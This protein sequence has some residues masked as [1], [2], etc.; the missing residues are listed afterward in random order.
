M[1]QN[2]FS[3]SLPAGRVAGIP[4]RLHW[5]LL[6]YWV[7]ELNSRL[8][9]EGD[10]KLIL[11]FWLLKVGLVFGSILLHELGHA[12]AARAVGGYTAE[13]LLWPLGGLA[14]ANAPHHW[15]AQLAVAAGG[16]L[17]TLVIVVAGYLVFELGA[18]F[19]PSGPG[20]GGAFVEISKVVLFDWNS[21]ILV[22]NLLP[23]YPLDGGRIFLACAWGFLQWRNA[24]GAY[25]RAVGM[26][27]WVARITAVAG[28]AFGLF[29]DQVQAV[30]IFIWAWMAAEQL[31][32]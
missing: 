16:P 2:L 12:F 5:L 19:L 26:T 15:K 23:L 20:V 24:F 10:R 13:I 17:V 29:Y 7:M 18:G 25:G 27:L 22:F 1:Y 9:G 3:W 4:V 11:L 30:V 8:A 21:I 32:R 28:I 6:L 31:R 14:F